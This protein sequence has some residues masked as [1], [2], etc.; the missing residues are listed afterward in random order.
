MIPP[1]RQ[2]RADLTTPRYMIR[3]NGIQIEGKQDITKR[4]GRSPDRGDA[5]V[6]AFAE[7]GMEGV[8]SESFGLIESTVERDWTEMR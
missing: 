2:L 4:I 3:S 6:Y 8:T 1:D 7:S 5:L